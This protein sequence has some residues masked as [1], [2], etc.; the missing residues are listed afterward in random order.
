MIASD[1][2]KRR[3]RKDLLRFTAACVALVGAYGAGL[4]ALFFISA[5]SA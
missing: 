4:L 3:E 5:R 2:S 1:A